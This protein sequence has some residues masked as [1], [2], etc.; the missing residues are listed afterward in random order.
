MHLGRDGGH[1][2]WSRVVRA[3]LAVHYCTNVNF[4]SQARVS[5]WE[6]NAIYNNYCEIP[7][8]CWSEFSWHTYAI[9]Y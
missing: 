6:I 9:L 2:W 7:Y 3:H 1:W 5:W 8:S 4:K